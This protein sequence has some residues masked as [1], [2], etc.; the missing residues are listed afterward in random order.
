[1]RNTITRITFQGTVTII[2]FSFVPSSAPGGILCKSANIFPGCNSLG[3]LY[4]HAAP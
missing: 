2:L 3:C 1:M 4:S